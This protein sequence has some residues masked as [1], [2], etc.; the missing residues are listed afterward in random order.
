[1]KSA[2]GGPLN[3]NNYKSLA[4]SVYQGSSV[5]LSSSLAPEPG[6]GVEE[7]V[8]FHGALASAQCL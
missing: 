3:T 6:A 5:V 1:M 2:L 7:V 4:I 8:T